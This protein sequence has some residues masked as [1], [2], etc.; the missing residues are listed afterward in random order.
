MFYMNV[1]T[2]LCVTCKVRISYFLIEI[3]YVSI[4]SRSLPNIPMRPF[5][6]LTLYKMPTVECGVGLFRTTRLNATGS[7]QEPG[8]QWCLH[9]MH[10]KS[11]IM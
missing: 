5:L 4:P 3:G 11:L 2:E 7:L 8:Y 10:Q 6:S 1:F 9:V